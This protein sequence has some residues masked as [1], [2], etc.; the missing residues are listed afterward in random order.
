M[1]L[2]LTMNSNAIGKEAEK[3]ILTIDSFIEDLLMRTKANSKLQQ[4]AEAF[5]KHDITFTEMKECLQK[6]KNIYSKQEEAILKI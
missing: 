4:A 6:M 5:S 2:H 3:V 1:A